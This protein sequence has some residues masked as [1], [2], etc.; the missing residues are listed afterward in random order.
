MAFYDGAQ[1]PHKFT[2]LIS[3]TE[4]TGNSSM[5]SRMPRNIDERLGEF[6]TDGHASSFTDADLAQ[7]SFLLQNSNRTCYGRVPR[8]YTVLRIINHLELLD[9]FLASNITDVLFPFDETTF[10]FAIDSKI[11]NKFLQH[12]SAVF[13][14]TLHLE[15]GE[16]GGHLY[17]EKRTSAPYDV[18]GRL[19]SGSFGEVQKVVSRLSNQEFARKLIR[20]TKYGRRN[21][22]GI[23]TFLAELQV[24]KRISHSHCV[25]LVCTFTF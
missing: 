23:K 4:S 15:A 24:L 25:E 13:T 3:I 6:F 2:N 20:R 11:R 8:L 18:K 16:R 19:G 5:S 22:P 17:L 10:P 1:L 7:V 21:E 14:K 12:Q 9:E